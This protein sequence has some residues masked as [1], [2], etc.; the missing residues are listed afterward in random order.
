MNLTGI[1]KNKRSQTRK[2]YSLH[3]SICVKDKHR[4]NKSMAMEV[5]IEFTFAGEYWLRGAQGH[6]LWCWIINIIDFLNSDLEMQSSKSSWPCRRFSP[7]NSVVLYYK[8][9]ALGH[10][11]MKRMQR[12]ATDWQKNLTI[13]RSN[14]ELVSSEMQ[15]TLNALYKRG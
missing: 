2:E 15:M 8:N 10:M 11:S 3:D 12:Q 4:Q 6:L 13:A 14:K 7:P 1:M 9:I 5:R